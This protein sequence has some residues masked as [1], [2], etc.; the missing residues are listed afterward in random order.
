MTESQRREKLVQEITALTNRLWASLEQEE[1]P[2]PTKASNDRLNGIRSDLH[3][4]VI[5]CN[6]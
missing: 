3:E 6:A 1:T 5:G 2:E 4:F